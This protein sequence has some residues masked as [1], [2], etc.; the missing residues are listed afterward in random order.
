M[1]QRVSSLLT[2]HVVRFEFELQVASSL[3]Y[4]TL[5]P[6]DLEVLA[7]GRST[8]RECSLLAGSAKHVAVRSR[9]RDV[10]EGLFL[11]FYLPILLWNHSN[12]IATNDAKHWAADRPRGGQVH[13]RTLSR[14]FFQTQGFGQRMPLCQ[15]KKRME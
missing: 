2:Q 4:D 6:A 3:R 7:N 1:V 11:F 14:R 15:G 13:T 10:R 9:Y 8:R 12:S 5:S